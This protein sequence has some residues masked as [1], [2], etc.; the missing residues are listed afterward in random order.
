MLFSVVS[1]LGAHEIVPGAFQ[2]DQ[3]NLD[4][5]FV[6]LT[7]RRLVAPVEKETA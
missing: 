1:L 4:D 6:T 2:V 5:A 7:G 3:P